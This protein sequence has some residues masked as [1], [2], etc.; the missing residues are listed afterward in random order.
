MASDPGLLQ[1]Q[2]ARAC[3]GWS[4]PCPS[5]PYASSKAAHEGLKWGAEVGNGVGDRGPERSGPHRSF[6]WSH[7]YP[8]HFLCQFLLLVRGQLVPKLFLL[9]SQWPLGTASWSIKWHIQRQ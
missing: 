5:F 2:L 9:L 4:F 7:K 3:R 6:C 8:F 1:N